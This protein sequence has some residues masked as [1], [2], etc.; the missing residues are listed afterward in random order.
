MRNFE[1]GERAGIKNSKGAASS[2]RR[3][4]CLTGAIVS[5]LLSGLARNGTAAP[6]DPVST[7]HAS[8]ATLPSVSGNPDAATKARIIETYGKLP[9]RFEAN[10]GQTDDQVKFLSRG[11]G[12]TLFL[13]PIEAVL[14]LSNQQS[15]TSSQQSAKEDKSEKTEIPSWTV[16][17]MKLVGGNA[18]P[19][20]TGMDPLPG[21]SNYFIGNDPKKWRTNVPNYAR[22]R[23]QDVY[24]GV[25][26]IYYGNTR[27]LEYDFVV[28]PG[29]DPTTITLAFVGSDKIEITDEGDLV[30]HI[31]GGKVIQRAP[32]IY[33]EVNSER[34]PINGR[35]VLHGKQQVGFHVA[36][37]DVTKPLV[38]DPDLIY[39]SYLGGTL[40]DQG[41]AVA[42]DAPGNAYVA[43]STVS[44]AFPGTAG[45][46]IQP[47]RGGLTDA[48]VT[49]VNA[50]GNALVY[51]TYLGG[52]GT[53]QA[54]GI[55]VNGVGEAYVTGV[56]DSAGVTPFP[57]AGAFQAALNGLTDAFVTKINAAGSALLYST[58]LGG[59]LD[60]QG[61]AIAVDTA[62]NAYITGSTESGGAVAFPT[63]GAA[64]DTAFNG[65]RDAFV[66]KF[67]PTQLV[68]ANTL[69]Y[70][71]F[72]GGSGSD[73][74]FG[75]AVDGALTAYVT[76]VT[77][78]AAVTLLP[79]T[80]GAFDTT[81]NGVQDAF[82]TRFNAAGSM[83]EYSTFLGGSL[84]DQGIAIAVDAARNAYVT[85]VTASG[86]A[87]PFP[88]IAG[89]LDTTFNGIQDAF[90]TKLNA[91]GT[92]LTYSTF[93]GGSAED[94]G[95]GIALDGVGNAYVTGDTRSAADFP[96]ADGAFLPAFGGV[97]D[98]FVTKLNAA[99]TALVYSTY[100][101]GSAI[102]IGHGI[103]VDPLDNAYV[104]GET[105]SADFPTASFQAVFGGV[106]DAF[107][108][109]M[110]EA[111]PAAGGGGG[112]GG[113]G[114]CF[115]ATA[116]FGSPM[117][118]QVQVLREFRDRYLL[119]NGP[120]RLFVAGYYRTSPP[121][122]KLIADSE[123]LRATVRAAL[124]PILGWAALILRYP[125]LALGILL[126]AL[127]LATW[128]A[129]QG[130]R[131]RQRARAS[132]DL[133]PTENHTGSDRS[134]VWRG[135]ALF[136]SLFLVLTLAALADAGE[137]DQ[138]QAADRVVLV[139]DVRLP[140]ATRFALIRDRVMGNLSLYKEGEAIFEGESPLPVGKV[141]ALRDEILVLALP[142]GTTVEIPRGGRLPG[143][144]RLIFARSAWIDALRFQLRFGTAP[145]P[146]RSYSVVDI[147]GGR[148]VLE[149]DAIP[150][151]GQAATRPSAISELHTRH[152]APPTVAEVVNRIPFAEVAPDTWEV[153]ERNINEL[154]N[155]LWPLLTETLRSATP[156]V[157]MTDGLGLRLDTSLGT[158][159]LDRE[160]FRIDYV[161]MARR[162][163]LEVGDRIL[164]VNDQPV[165]SA[166]G[167]VRIYKALKSDASLS[168]V[169]VVIRRG[170]EVRTLT[171][172]L[173]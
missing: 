81:P 35:F 22:V 128:L 97:T 159:T 36:A 84:N 76:G 155:H 38:I 100:L 147:F 62:N 88:T 28:A 8:R 37:Y 12:Y 33:Q 14:V 90:V 54:F 73:E 132:R 23:Y 11:H 70:S 111:A 30:L 139:G 118:P 112:G 31:T 4:I 15:A 86:G 77:D 66:A 87:T 136:G 40:T 41:F 113:G 45:S 85:G 52:G 18:N 72:L 71:T 154:G 53:D 158:G 146:H 161:K 60:D 65:I 171:Y 51:S 39:S 108:T 105:A 34:V 5:L 151:E 157:T 6:L 68:A 94:I 98:A 104:T 145:A 124:L 56:T 46:A 80:A 109:K 27:Q 129:I 47:A 3:W 1:T 110:T 55:A 42:V 24:P 10:R 123:T 169:N 127:A 29:V 172:R 20:I 49:K 138:S 83:Q 143:P 173:R 126:V 170:V 32:F 7:L 48:F 142:G 16:V 101:G 153:P 2:G 149:R 115:I 21:K 122:A 150:G 92:A 152:T 44:D 59:S 106:N 96:T 164:S 13:T 93:L 117:A 82:V 26:L 9:L 107:V 69:V 165:N 19:K 163:G 79:T 156:V 121:I 17:R 144:H 78:S 148:A 89:A 43:G 119:T 63:T 120:G 58:Y 133:L 166:G 50:A 57:T 103:A 95:R 64:F 75:I 61:N 91:T 131:R 167:L 67:D 162:T 99:G 160:G 140:Q 102:D 168:E 134:V 125:S 141:A 116:T 130:A 25:D 74:G 135:L 114:F 137:G